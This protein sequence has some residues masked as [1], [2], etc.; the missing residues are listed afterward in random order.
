MHS[1]NGNR[2]SASFFFK[3]Q[4]TDVL[5][6]FQFSTVTVLAVDGAQQLLLLVLPI[7]GAGWTETCAAALI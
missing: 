6:C 4:S 3:T 1:T 7:G 5:F 2:L